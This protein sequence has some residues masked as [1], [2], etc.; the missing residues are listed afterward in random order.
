[1]S[2]IV[3][4]FRLTAEEHEQIVEEQIALK[5][6][7]TSK[8][9][10]AKLLAKSRV[11]DRAMTLFSSHV[12]IICNTL[13]RSTNEQFANPNDAEHKNNI[14]SIIET[15]KQILHDHHDQQG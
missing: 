2:K 6:Q 4:T 13:M 10:R 7:D 12:A 8:Y 11:M 15:L 14:L 5:Y 9:I 3:K 1:M